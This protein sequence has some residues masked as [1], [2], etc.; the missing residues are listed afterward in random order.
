MNKP[1]QSDSTKVAVL[2]Q[3]ID[4]LKEDVKE[5]KGMVADKI[6]TKEYVDDRVNPLKKLVYTMLGLAGTL[7][8]GLVLAVVGLALNRG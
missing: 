7:L 1:R 8:V 3:K 5:V 6:A 2:S 4:D